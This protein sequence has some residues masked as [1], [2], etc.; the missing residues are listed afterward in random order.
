[1]ARDQKTRSKTSQAQKNTASN[2]RVA[3]VTPGQAQTP[4]IAHTSPDTT[5]IAPDNAQT[6]NSVVTKDADTAS[7]PDETASTTNTQQEQAAVQQNTANDQKVAW[8]GL[9]PTWPTWPTSKPG[10]RSKPPMPGTRSINKLRSE[11]FMEVGYNQQTGEPVTQTPLRSLP[12]AHTTGPSSF[13]QPTAQDVLGKR[14]QR[15]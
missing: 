9:Q 6:T 14:K 2:Q 12:D 15:L 1:M 8:S 4:A 5:N 11:Q 3:P 10:P 7:I 13:D